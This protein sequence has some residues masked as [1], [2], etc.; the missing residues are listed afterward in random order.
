MKFKVMTRKG[1]KPQLKELQIPVDSD[2]TAGL[3][4]RQAKK[5]DHEEM[6]QRVLDIERRQEEEDYQG[7]WVS[8]ALCIIIMNFAGRH[9]ITE[10][11]FRKVLYGLWQ[12]FAKFID[13]FVIN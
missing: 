1:H 4:D 3:K 13:K 9:S 12:P 10:I 5:E 2:L 11:Y 8:F 6:K 7:G